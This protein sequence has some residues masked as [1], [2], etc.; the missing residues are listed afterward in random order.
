[1]SQ[2]RN[3]PGNRIGQIQNCQTPLHG[4]H[5]KNPYNPQAAGASQRNNRRQHGV[6][7]S[8]DTSN[9]GIH[10]STDEIGSTDNGH[11]EQSI[12]NHLRIRRIY[13]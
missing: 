3:R 10:N 11:P 1:M 4:K 7:D 9:H 12:G 2:S 8:T 6:A 5:G 13:L